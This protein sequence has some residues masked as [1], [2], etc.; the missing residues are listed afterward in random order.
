MKSYERVSHYY[1]MPY[2]NRDAEILQGVILQHW[3][4]K[5]PPF[6]YF[7]DLT[8]VCKE[9]VW[10]KLTLAEWLKDIKNTYSG[11]IT[12][13]TLK[14][15]HKRVLKEQLHCFDVFKRPNLGLRNE[16]FKPQ[17][18]K[19]TSGL[20]FVAVTQEIKENMEYFHT[21][22]RALREI[23][24][25]TNFK[26]L[27]RWE[28]ITIVGK[29]YEGCFHVYAQQKFFKELEVSGLMRRRACYF[30][31]TNHANLWNI[32]FFR[33]TCEGCGESLELDALGVPN[34]KIKIQFN[35]AAVGPTAIKELSYQTTMLCANRDLMLNVYF[36]KSRTGY[37]SFMAGERHKK[38]S[39]AS[40]M[41]RDF[42]PPPDLFRLICEE[43]TLGNNAIAQLEMENAVTLRRYR[44]NLLE[45][46]DREYHTEIKFNKMRKILEYVC[47]A[48]IAN[49][50][51]EMMED[52]EKA[53]TWVDLLYNQLCASA[54]HVKL[55]AAL[56]LDASHE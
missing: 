51:K 48:L 42:Y 21:L 44:D 17:V 45:S 2:T 19:S 9:S 15:F 27:Y 43:R 31:M 55:P 24:T 35:A 12:E 4:N 40:Y 1:R 13:Q 20:A 26:M 22:V 41:A 36:A 6:A 25:V 32:Q 18:Y 7:K 37:V 56:N 33:L 28:Q 29:N 3:E 53:N 14:F 5:K 47:P 52:P 30:R 46:R 50:N 54:D 38:I 10:D 49:A 34:T 11:Q 39:I 16:E 8:D 23:N